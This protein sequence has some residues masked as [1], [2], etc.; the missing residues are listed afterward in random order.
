LREEDP[1]GG[2]VNLLLA[3]VAARDH[4]P[5]DAIIWYQ[6]AIYGYWPDNGLANRVAARFELVDYLER[7]G[8]RS[9]VVAQL[10]ELAG[11]LPE[12]DLAERER[13]GRLLLRYGSPEHAAETLRGLVA[14]APRNPSA[15]E[16]LGEAEF[17]LGEYGAA[18]SA[19]RMAQRYGS[20]DPQLARRIEACDE[21]VALDPTLVHLTA[22]ER[23]A[24]AREVLRLTLD[25][26]LS[27]WPPPPGLEAAALEALSRQPGR[28]REGDTLEVLGLAQTLWKARPQDCGPDD[29]LGA[30]PALM[31]RLQ[32]Q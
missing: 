32:K 2:T 16:A 12:D 29:F 4:R 14:S 20:T 15:Q 26:S 22:S 23:Y 6:R 30:L 9:Q 27:C 31:A 11:E 10:M 21:V 1:T 7:R 8:Q 5:K 18:R 13:V 25:A 28:K 3:R 24:R 19:F 17:A